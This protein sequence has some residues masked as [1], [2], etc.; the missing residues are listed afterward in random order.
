[1]TSSANVKVSFTPQQII[2]LE[3]G[4]CHLYAAVIQ[5]IES[6]QT[7]WI[8]PLCLVK[9]QAGSTHHITSL[10]RTS[11]VIVPQ[12]TFREAWDT[13]I[14]EFWTTLYDESGCYEDNSAGRQI[15][16]Q[17]LREFHWKS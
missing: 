1:M 10:H 13:E 15:L 3:Q 6:Q 14:V 4:D 16:Q 8:R 17:F 9:I 2:C 7:Y 11:D 5:F 12:G